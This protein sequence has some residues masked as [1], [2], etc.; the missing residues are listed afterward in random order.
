M[1]DAE[2][3][4]GN[5]ADIVK[6]V[7]APPSTALGGLHDPVVRFEFSFLFL[8]FPSLVYGHSSWIYVLEF[9]DL[10]VDFPVLLLDLAV[11]LVDTAEQLTKR[12][13]FLR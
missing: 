13:I 11:L 10:V 8:Q 1:N 9:L 4:V 5:V 12:Y 7:N 3:P 2:L 6:E